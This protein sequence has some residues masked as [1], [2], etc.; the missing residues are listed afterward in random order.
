MQKSSKTKYV[1]EPINYLYIVESTNYESKV[2][3]FFIL[4]I[5]SVTIGLQSSI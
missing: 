3:T 4:V 5:T 1:K 2:V